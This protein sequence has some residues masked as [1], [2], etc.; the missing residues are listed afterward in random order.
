MDSGTAAS[1]EMLS[2]SDL[3]SVCA[4]GGSCITITLPAYHPGTRALPYST[5][6][7]SAV[8]LAERLLVRNDMPEDREAL[9]APLRELAKGIERSGSGP[10]RAIFRS[11][12]MFRQFDLP[13]PAP[14]G[15]LVGTYFQVLPLL[16]QLCFERQ[17]YILG[18][19]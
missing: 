4:S 18:L 14:L 5:N 19:S 8:R 3:P 7:K 2:W 12:Q 15:T 17:F 1:S 9:L 16:G 11:R 13:G 6:L 10:A